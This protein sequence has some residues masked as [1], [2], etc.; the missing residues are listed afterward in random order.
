M[1]GKESVV[2]T[3]SVT[4]AR[5]NLYFL[6]DEVS[7]GHIPALLKGKDKNAVLISE[8][9]WIA[10]CE[11]LRLTSIPGMLESLLNGMNEPLSECVSE[12]RVKV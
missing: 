3:V 4:E 8:E 2:I 6:V 1:P 7:A 10:V 9:D 11:T 5:D 12:D